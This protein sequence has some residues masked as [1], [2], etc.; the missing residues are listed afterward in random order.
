M[1][2]FNGLLL[3][4]LLSISFASVGS[5]N[6]ELLSSGSPVKVPALHKM[7]LQEYR[8]LR[9]QKH[10]QEQAEAKK[11]DLQR[12]LKPD[13]DLN[14]S[15]YEAVVTYM[16]Q[17]HAQFPETTE[18]FDLGLND[19]SVMIKGI[20]IGFG[21]L[22][23]LVVATHHGNEYGSAEIAK[24]FAASIAK[25][26]LMDQSIY[27]IPVLN[28]NGYNRNSRNE[29][30]KGESFDP[31]RDYQGPCISNSDHNLNSTRLLAEFLEKKNI[32]SSMT[33][34]T[35]F[36]AITYPWGV[37]SSTTKTPDQ[38]FFEQLA[39]Y[40]ATGNN[41]YIGTSADVVYPADGTFEDFAYWKYGV[42]SLLYEIGTS[43][44]PSPTTIEK[45]IRETVPGMKLVFKNSRLE[46]SKDFAFKGNCNARVRSF[47]PHME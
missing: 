8:Q 38:S 14:A 24:A 15:K 7:P 29:T 31:N 43:H 27:I 41:Y 10:F 18:L 16:E 35:H 45:L 12:Q 34:H 39:K 2:H 28:I 17:L 20:R 26:P 40:A 32:I 37:S 42:W 23:N 9:L 22:N 25:E 3:S 13:Q 5:A 33:L 44:T 4:V 21:S 1:T 46:R 11:R 6:E 19:D 36:P 30:K 47:D